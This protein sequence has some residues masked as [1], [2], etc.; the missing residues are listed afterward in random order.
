MNDV[1]FA[2]FAH[3]VMF[4]EQFWKSIPIVAK[5][6][7][8]F[9]S[10]SFYYL[11]TGIWVSS[12]SQ[13]QNKGFNALTTS[14]WTFYHKSSGDRFRSWGWTVFERMAMFQTPFL[15]KSTQPQQL[16][17]CTK[18]CTEVSSSEPQSLLLKV[19]PQAKYH[20]CVNSST[21]GFRGC[22]GS[23][24]EGAVANFNKFWTKNAL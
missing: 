13:Y 20:F 24:K 5:N 1:I 16:D 14:Q 18:L 19:F 3:K 2:I 6:M 22:F 4:I 15:S 17:C 12:G 9:Y 10:L 23:P 21:T 11:K 7:H 8:L